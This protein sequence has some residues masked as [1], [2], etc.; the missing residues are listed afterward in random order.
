M[1]WWRAALAGLLLVGAAAP[2]A[3]ADGG[4]ALGLRL[5]YA[6]PLGEAVAGDPLRRTFSGAVPLQVEGGWRAGPVYGGLYLQYGFGLLAR[7]FTSSFQSARGADLRLGAEGRVRLGAL[8]GTMPWVGAGAGWEWAFFSVRG[9]E[10]GTLSLSGPEG[11]LGAGADLPL[12]GAHG[13]I[14]PFLTLQMG[15][16]TR[17]R[18]EGAGSTT[19]LALGSRS[20][21]LWLQLGVRGSFEM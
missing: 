11:S 21:H 4:A 10:S 7:P 17:V 12:P 20:V 19:D 2:A 18:A 8:G 15:Q 6:V 5:G 13:A 9:L 3:R 1:G 14:G 16:Y